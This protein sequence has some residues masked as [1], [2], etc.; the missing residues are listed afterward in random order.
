MTNEPITAGSTIGPAFLQI[1][2]SNQGIV[3]YRRR[4]LSTAQRRTLFEACCAG[5]EHPDC[6]ICGLPVLP[7]QKWVESHMPVP[8]ALDGVETGVGH[9]LCNRERWAKVEAPLLAKVGRQRDRHL[10]IRRSR[11][12]LPGGRED[13][14]KRTM[15]G[16][17]VN[18]ATGEEWRLRTSGSGFAPRE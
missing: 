18:R 13:P 14:R 11:C 1:S 2:P 10:D 3:M 8:H 12:P 16:R 5:K 4:R 15:D 6:N 7:G 17:V 9:D